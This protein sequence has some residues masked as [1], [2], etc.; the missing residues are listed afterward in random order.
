[1]TLD[2]EYP[3]SSSSLFS[4]LTDKTGQESEVSL[5]MMT[6]MMITRKRG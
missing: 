3:S 6:M 2:S 5:L 1:M 4:R